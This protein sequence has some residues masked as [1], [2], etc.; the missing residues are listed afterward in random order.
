MNKK[1]RKISFLVLL[2][3]IAGLALTS[4][5]K[6]GSDK[7]ANEL[8]S[9]SYSYGILVGSSFKEQLAKSL[10]DKENIDVFLNGLATSI[11]GDS[12]KISPEDAEELIQNYMMKKE[13]ERA[14][15]NENFL[16]ENAKKA[17][18]ITTA[19]GLQYEIIKEGNGAKPSASSIV[20]VHYHGTFIDA[21]VFDSSVERG[22]PVEFPL[23]QVIPGWTEGV[24]LMSIGSKYRFTIPSHLAYG[25]RGAGPVA[26]NSTLIF[27]VELLD[28]I[29]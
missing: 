27:E 19:S 4:C 5:N 25:Q 6:V 11:K 20:K 12:G 7:M 17:G 3:S 24:Q 14:E 23:D 16:E 15:E 8:D 2:A 10:D 28:I 13:S 26:P 22:E 1:M 18:V 9:V 21:K 29:K